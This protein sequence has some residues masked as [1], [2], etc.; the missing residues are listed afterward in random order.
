MVFARPH[1]GAQQMSI[2]WLQ[3]TR[4]DRRLG[5][6][7]I[8]LASALGVTVAATVWTSQLDESPEMLVLP[9][10]KAPAIAGSQTIAV[11][12]TQ[13]DAAEHGLLRR[14]PWAVPV[15][16]NLVAWQPMI[17]PQPAAA[18]VTPHQQGSAPPA[19]VAPPF[20][21]RMIGRLEDE[22]GVQALLAGPQR[23]HA[24]RVGDTLDEQWRIEAITPHG[25]QL[26]WL[27]AQ[28][29]QTLTFSGS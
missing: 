21:Y 3:R 11:S 4:P 14:A 28:L 13:H 17:A 22:Q 20:P 10:A 16:Q 7:D 15:A 18:P 9:R 23:S 6:R 1:S 8:L 25:L 5:R 2:N 24:A 27:P 19:Q 26:L 29:P 12:S